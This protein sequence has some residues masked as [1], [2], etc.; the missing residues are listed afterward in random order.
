MRYDPRHEHSQEPGGQGRPGGH[1]GHPGHRFLARVPRH[2]GRSRG[3]GGGGR[4]R[5][6]A[7][8][9]PSASSISPGTGCRTRWWSGPSRP[10]A[11]STR[12]PSTEKMRLQLNENNIG[13]L[14]VNQ[15]IQKASTVHKATRPNYNESF[16]ISHDRAADHPDVL[17]GT[18]LRGRN[19]W[20]DGH[21]AMRA[22]MVDLLHH[23]AGGGGA[24]AAGA[25]ARARDAGR[26]LRP[27][28][29]GRGAHQSALPAL[30]APGHRG[31]RAVRAGAAHRQL[32][33][34]D[35]G[36]DGRAGARGAAAV[37]GVAGAAADPGDVPGQPRQHD[38]AV[39]ERPLPLDAARG[40][41][42]VRGPTATRSR[43]STARRRPR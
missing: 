35:P 28:L 20:P 17:A 26:P 8:A 19:Q 13:Y 6:G 5:C 37:G 16:F 32:V 12:C 23:A 29:R 7:P 38:E 25:G 9:R 15:S 21:A 41:E 4:A 31:R 18:P 10:R 2:P 43:S 27:V 3:A 40:A 39:V 22:A 1:A 11:S 14:P 33:H 42:R 36:P 30:P 24:H 34:H